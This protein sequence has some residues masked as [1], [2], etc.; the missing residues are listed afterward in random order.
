MRIVSLLPSAT[1]I[2][3]ALGLEDEIV[4]VSPEC[5]YP[6]AAR[7][8][9]VVSQNLIEPEAMGQGDIDAAVVAHLREGGALYHVNV[10]K[11]RA[12]APDVIFTQNLCE[13][14]AASVQDVT[15]VAAELPK[16]PE[17]VSLD[18]SDLDEVIR[19]IEKV[20]A[21]TGRE[22]ESRALVD[23]LAARLD[24][25]AERILGIAERPAVACIEWYDPLFNAGHWVP[26][27][28]ELAGGE[29]LLA[30]RGRPSRRIDW[31]DL[32][33]AAPDVVLLMP[34]GFG[35]QRAV[36]DAHFMTRLPGWRDL[37]AVRRGHVFA[38]DGSSYFS[39]PGPRLVEGVELLAHLFHP[40]RFPKEWPKDAVQRMA[41]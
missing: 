19:C 41:G 27:M 11:L 10:E 2:L 6:P 14:C 25:V 37:P 18:P 12:A 20:G 7:T 13:V 33:H 3:F 30:Q 15:A 32:V 4:G 21:E 9:P 34:C 29:E 36:K 40:E 31:R 5:D 39:R 22:A 23:S 8:K 16:R 24:A 38:V 17:I 28:V 1:E 26:Q 35:I